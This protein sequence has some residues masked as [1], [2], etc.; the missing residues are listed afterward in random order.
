[1]TVSMAVL[2]DWRREKV[3]FELI[4]GHPIELN[5]FNTVKMG[6]FIRSPFGSLMGGARPLWVLYL[7]QLKYR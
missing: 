4:G 3:G 1:M 2:F 6:G 5:N 7:K